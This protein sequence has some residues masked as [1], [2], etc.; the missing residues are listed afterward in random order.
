MIRK[1]DE[2]IDI[3]DYTS[4][5]QCSSLLGLDSISSDDVQRLSLDEGVKPQANGGGKIQPLIQNNTN[6][7]RKMYCPIRIIG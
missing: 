2:L 7:E 4:Y 3:N 5:D 6:N 1:T